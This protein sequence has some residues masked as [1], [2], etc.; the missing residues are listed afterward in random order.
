[1]LPVSHAL[2][3]QDIQKAGT[4]RIGTEG[5]FKPFNYFEGKK[6]TGFEVDLANALAKHMN[7]KVQ[8]IPQSFDSLLI[9]LNQNRYDFVIA[10]HGITPERQKAVDF[11]DPHYCTGGLIVSKPGGPKTAKDLMGKLVAV[12]VGTSYLD[13]VRKVAGVKDVKTYARDPDAEQ[14]LLSGRVDAWVS[15][16]F[17]ALD[18]I[19]A[20]GTK[21]QAGDLLFQ[22]KVAMA[23]QKGNTTLK[24]ELNKALKAILASGEYAKI[25]QK[26]F[27]QDIRCK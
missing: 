4:I 15:D 23:V 12:Q 6:L 19:K 1:M 17:L 11:T 5:A 27:M 3:F 26:Y 2:P 14:A 13:N 20:A 18:A 24:T 22:E 9:G 16:K 21:I 10:S 25:S 8:W 7:L